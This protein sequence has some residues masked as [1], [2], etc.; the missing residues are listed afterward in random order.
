[1]EEAAKILR[2]DVKTLCNLVRRRKIGYYK[3]RPITFSLEHIA[4]YKKSIEVKPCVESQSSSSSEGQ[5]ENSNP[6]AG[7]LPIMTESEAAAVQRAVKSARKTMKPKSSLRT[8]SL[9]E[10]APPEAR[11]N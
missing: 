10:S 4:A 8:L 6:P 1:M 2:K 5:P 3:G 9:K 11:A 7:T